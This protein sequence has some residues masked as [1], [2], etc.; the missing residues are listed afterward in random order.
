MAILL[1]TP[2]QPKNID[3]GT[4]VLGVDFIS[5]NCQAKKLK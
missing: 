4:K 3:V 2:S 1:S 5:I